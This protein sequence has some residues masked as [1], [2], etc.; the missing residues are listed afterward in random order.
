MLPFNVFVDKYIKLI[1][2]ILYESDTLENRKSL[3]QVEDTYNDTNAS[4]NA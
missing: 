2:V 4:H 3:T 1:Y